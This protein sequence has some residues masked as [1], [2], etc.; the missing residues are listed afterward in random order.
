VAALFSC[1]AGQQSFETTRAGG[2]HG[3]FFHFVLEGLRGK[4]RKG[5]TGEVTWARLAE[6]VQENVE[7]RVP[8]WVGPGSRQVP[9]EVKNL[10]G[11]SPVLLRLDPG[12]APPDEQKAEAQ[13]G[14]PRGVRPAP[15]VLPFDDE[16]AKE[17]Q[18]QWAGYLGTKM[19][20]KNSVG[21][22]LVLIPAGKFVMGSPAAE[23]A[24]ARKSAKDQGY[25]PAADLY[26]DEEQHAVEIT[27]PFYLGVYEVTQAE[28][29]KVMG[30]GI[31]PSH[32][33]RGG[34]G[35]DK[36][37]GMDTGRF[38]AEKVSWNDAVEFCTRLSE[39]DAERR[40]GRKYRL[41]T[42]AEWE[43]ACRAGGRATNPVFFG[44]ALSS[45][46]ANFDGHHP[47]GGA[48]KGR[49][50]GRPAPVGS[51]RPNAF[52][53]YDTHGN[54]WEWCAD[55]YGKD[56]YRT[57]PKRDP[58]NAAAGSR[59]LRVLRGGSWWSW[60][61]YCRTAVRHRAAPGDRAAD[62][63][64]RVVFTTP[65]IAATPAPR[66]VKEEEEE[67]ESLR[68]RRRRVEDPDRPDKR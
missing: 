55:Y 36:V 58:R 40:A 18:R 19:V 24:Q 59:E 64:F 52:G 14:A 28:Y 51:Y 66:E 42:E 32:F 61:E 11:R 9:N 48:E 62:V 43:Y 5:G 12:P 25:N 68:S 15:A 65:A 35:K 37:E 67:L 49:Y 3:V 7:A 17:H 6:Y 41:P 31:A 50:L 45:E 57:G 34:K 16:K 39:L 44:L 2:G 13:G 27:R 1:S 53:L 30:S 22:E 54:V 63:G 60:G 4:A 56:Y 23:Q 47:F 10:S 33:S 21:M 26:A 8:E 29:E 46:L 38:P 20:E